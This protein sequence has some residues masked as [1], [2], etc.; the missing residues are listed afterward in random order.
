M[1]TDSFEVLVW[2]YTTSIEEY[3]RAQQAPKSELPALTDEQELVAR[4]FKISEEE[5]A[6]GVLAGIYGR[7]RQ[8]ARGRRLGKEVQR[9]LGDLGADGQVV[10]VA[11]ETARLRWVVAI[12]VTEGI[13]GVAVPR[14]LADDV[15]DWAIHDR[16]E[17]LRARVADAVR[18]AGTVAKS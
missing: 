5:Y 9:I 13:V 6:R 11:Y 3:Q 4:R 14:E 18:P 12:K 1:S 16:T 8:R 7:E 17:E 2:D 10:R 15:L